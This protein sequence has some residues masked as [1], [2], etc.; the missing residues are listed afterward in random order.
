MYPVDAA[1]IDRTAPNPAAQ[2][3][4]AL[5]V[6]M[7]R[8]LRPAAPLQPAHLDDSIERDLAL[9]SLS[10]AELLLR[11]E[12]SFGIRL[13][14]RLA[15]TARTP[16]DLLA[17]I[18]A[19]EPGAPVLALPPT[20][21]PAPEPVEGTPEHAK[22]MVEAFLWHVERHPERDHIMLLEGDEIRETLSYA[23]LWEG[24][25]EVAKGLAVRGVSRGDAVALM[26]PTG[27]AF[28]QAFLGAMRIG[29]VPVPM[30]PPLRWAEIEEHVRG[31]AAILSNAQA[32][33]LVTV[34]E[35]LFIGRILGAQLP[36]LGAVI[37]VDRLRGDGLQ[38]EAA[39][40][41]GDETAMLQYTSGSTGDPKGVVLSHDNLLANIRVMG[42]AAAVTSSDRFVSWLPLYHDMGLIGAW[43]ATMY[44]AVPL[45]LMPPADFLA[46][47]AR[48]PR[49]IHRYGATISAGPN[50][51]YE[52]VASKVRDED[53]VGLDLRA[54][55]LAF[56]GAEPVRAA[57]LERFAARFAR[58]GFDRRA[59]TP[60]YGLAESTLG[61][62][63]PPLGRGP[64]IDR[65]D[66][67]ALS[68]EGNAIRLPQSA[69]D[70]LEVVSCGRPLPGYEVRVVDD[71][72]REIAARSEGRLEFRGPSATSG[73]FRNP[74]ATAGLFRGDWLDTGDIGY[75]AEGEIFLTSR[76][77]D[78][79]KRGGHNLHPYDLE[80]AI[81][82]I[83]GMRKGCVA[84]FG[85][86]DR[87]TGTE[88]VIVVA[89]TSQADA[90]A[91]AALRDRI[92]SLAAIHLNGPADEVLLVPARTVLKTSSGKIRRAACRELYERGLLQAP[93]G[94]VWLQL[95]RLVRQ[96]LTAR[97]GRA[98]RALAQVAYG[99]YCWVFFVL[100]SS[101]CLPVLAM[102]SSPGA[103][104]RLARGV[105]RTLVR[106]YGLSL[107]VKGLEHLPAGKPTVIAVNH[108]SYIDAMILVAV[109]PPDIHF[110]AKREF[111]RVPLIGFVMRRLGAY[112][113]ERVDPA[114]GIEDTRDV[115]AAV[116]RGE[117]LVFFPEGTF[118][119][120]P[121]LAAFRL[122]A[123]VVSA[124]SGVPVLPIVLRG[125]RSALRERRWLLVRYP[126][127]MIV[128]P[129]VTPAGR[130]WSAA[131][132]LRDRVRDV[133]LRDCGEPDLAR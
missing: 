85:T 12:R 128:E 7:L 63:F 41:G 102:L 58:Y 18:A 76:A 100:L 36:H 19:A 44:Y 123:F 129:P 120:A 78:L 89:E 93:R 38:T 90:T 57:T 110:S 39:R 16:R 13:P 14:E 61:L 20:S 126:I 23:R 73:Y 21:P 130:D 98:L 11:I 74:K 118:S 3:L 59:L 84:V 117:T 25:G 75:I 109:L 40:L 56:N 37:S 30:Y 66:A 77:K 24:A 95:A 107:L 48:W 27:S 42:R 101:L 133:I 45:V 2:R 49:T 111:D 94:A 28:F 9:D 50:F 124:E 105:A 33:V 22:T 26:L 62:G 132:Q 67:S 65:I 86:T 32:R 29:A 103:R 79:I 1:L 119:R 92:T 83:P 115:L 121:G 96:A 60:V 8:E 113:V 54:W 64:R 108:A 68:R 97:L 47:P 5:I 99:A 53:L 71:A 15:T 88:R 91:R 81:G 131:V 10:R 104:M 87:S 34:P 43:L 69:S 52:I 35:G 6:E 125:T 70:G 122:G 46:R 116:R 106:G 17:A 114:R 82:D 4:L 51:A 72:G 31:R 55:R 112:F 80:A 127:E